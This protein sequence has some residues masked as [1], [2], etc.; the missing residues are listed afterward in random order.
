LDVT[1]FRERLQHLSLDEFKSMRMSRNIEAVMNQMN[2]GTFMYC[3]TRLAETTGIWIPELVPVFRKL[4]AH[5]VFSDL[6]V[7][8]ER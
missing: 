7:G 6:P 4:D 8:I 5:L 1:V 2:G 3:H